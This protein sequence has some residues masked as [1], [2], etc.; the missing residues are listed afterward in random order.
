MWPWA[1]YIIIVFLVFDEI[2]TAWAV[3]TS[4]FGAFELKLIR[5]GL[6]I[7]PSFKKQKNFF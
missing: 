3:V 4:A 2:W 1:L 6:I 7:I 5:K